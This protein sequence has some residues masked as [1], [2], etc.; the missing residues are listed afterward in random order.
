MGLYN[1]HFNVLRQVQLHL[2]QLALNYTLRYFPDILSGDRLVSILLVGIELV[3][4]LLRMSHYISSRDCPDHTIKVVIEL[5]FQ[6]NAP[7]AYIAFSQ[8]GI[9]ALWRILQV[10]LDFGDI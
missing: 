3:D 2:V 8:A 9:F 6:N 7:L 1:L 5:G 4:F 10:L